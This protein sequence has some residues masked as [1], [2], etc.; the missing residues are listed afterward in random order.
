[1][2]NEQKKFLRD[3]LTTA[4]RATWER[5]IPEPKGRALPARVRKAQALI[6]RS[7]LV[8]RKF[9]KTWMRTQARAARPLLKV[10]AAA[11]REILFGTVE[12][13]LKLTERAEF[14]AK[15]LRK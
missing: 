8:L 10:I 5:N 2:N 4:E 1:M 11:Q 6:K 14:L 7:E 13:A 15:Q 3:R 12:K 9:R